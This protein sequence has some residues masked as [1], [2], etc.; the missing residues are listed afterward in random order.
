MGLYENYQQKQPLVQAL[1]TLEMAAGQKSLEFGVFES[2]AYGTGGAALSAVTAITNSFAALGTSIGVLDEGDFRVSTRDAME[3]LMGGRA[4]DFYGEYSQGIEITGLVAGS[5]VPGLAAVRALRAMQVSGKVP[6]VLRPITGQRNP[7]ML[8]GSNLVESAK[9]SVLRSDTK[10]WRSQETWRA[11]RG[12]FQQQVMENIAFEAGMLA[13]MNQHSILNPEGTGYFGAMAGQAWES[14]PFLGVSVALGTGI[15]ALRI[16]GAINKFV[17]SEAVRTGKYREYHIGA[18]MDNAAV[19]AGDKI[20]VVASEMTRLKSLAR[21]TVEGDF[22]ATRAHEQ[23]MAAL[24]SHLM[25]AITEVNFSGQVGREYA[26][27]IV[28][29]AETGRLDDLAFVMAGLARL[30]TPT[31]TDWREGLRFFEKGRAPKLF[32]RPTAQEAA[33]DF[34]TDG[35]GMASTRAADDMAAN[36]VD[37]FGPDMAKLAKSKNGIYAINNLTVDVPYNEAAMI[38]DIAAGGQMPVGAVASYGKNTVRNARVIIDDHTVTGI[39]TIFLAPNVLISDAKVIEHNWKI[40]VKMNKAAGMRQPSLDEYTEFLVMHELSHLKSNRLV[41]KKDAIAAIAELKGGNTSGR[42]ILDELIYGTYKARGSSFLVTA[43]NEASKAGVDPSIVSFLDEV[44]LGLEK[45]PSEAAKKQ[46]LG[47]LFA[48]WV[49]SGQ[50]DTIQI[51]GKKYPAITL[52]GKKIAIPDTS[53][54]LRLDELLAD[55]GAVLTHSST[56]EL[57]SKTMPNVARIMN[58]HGAIARAWNPERSFVD[59][60]TGQQETTVLFRIADLAGGA[61]GY[62]IQTAGLATHLIVPK[63]KTTFVSNPERFAGIS[64]LYAKAAAG[65]VPKESYLAYDAEWLIASKQDMQSLIRDDGTM[66][67]KYSHLPQLER[68][69]TQKSPALDTLFAK[70]NF[71]MLTE[72]GLQLG[73]TK[74]GLR[75]HLATE[76]Q[77]YRDALAATNVYSDAEIARILNISPKNALGDFSDDGWTM[78]DKWEHGEQRYLAAAYKPVTMADAEASAKSRVAV[79]VRRQQ[80]DHL[81]KLTS[82]YVIPDLVQFLPQI[83]VERIAIMSSAESRAGM[84][85]N[86]RPMF[87]SV[88]V[89]MQHVGRLVEKAAVQR[90]QEVNNRMVK[91]SNH[92]NKRE[93]GQDRFQLAQLE[94]VA[95]RAPYY[96]LPTKDGHAM[97]RKSAIEGFAVDNGISFAEAHVRLSNPQTNQLAIRGMIGQGDQLAPDAILPSRAIGDFFAEHIS[98]NRVFIEKDIALAGAKGRAI[99]RDPHAL[100]TPPRDLS[101]SRY[102]AFVVPK[103]FRADAD[104]RKFMVYADTLDEYQHK[105]AAIQSKYGDE[106]TV[107]TKDDV[108]EFKKYMGDYDQGLIFDEVYFDANMAR[109][110]NASELLPGVDLEVSGT[111]SR[112]HNWYINK[113]RAILRS[114]VETHYAETF[115]YLRSMDAATTAKKAAPFGVKFAD[116]T[117][118]FKDSEYLMLG[119]RASSGSIEDGWVRVNGFIGEKGSQL[120]DNALGIFRS[121]IGSGVTAK[122]LDEFNTA[123]ESAGYKAPF[124]GVMETVLISPDPQVSRALPSLVRTMNNL[125]GTLM[126]R[127]DAAHQIVTMISTPILALPVLMEA[128]A[129]MRGTPGGARLEAMTTVVNP[130]TGAKEPTAARLIYDGMRAFFSD[131]GK[132]FMAELRQQGVISDYLRQYQEVLDFSQINGRHQM[133]Q[134]NDKIDQLAA[135]GSR[136]S[137]FTQTEEFTRFYVAWAAKTIGEARGLK[138]PELM[139]VVASSVDKVHGIYIGHQRPQLFQGVVGQAIGLYQTYMFNF[140]QNLTKYVGDGDKAMAL[141]LAGMQSTVFG[142]QSWPGFTTFNQLIGETNRGN[143]DIYEAFDAN[144]PKATGAYFMYGLGSHVLGT[145]IDFYSRGDMAIRNALIVPN[146]LDPMQ[147]PAV[148]MFA[149][150][151]GNIYNVTKM[152]LGE[153]SVDAQEAILHG[154][155]HNGMNRPLQGLAK[156]MQGQI[157]SG[158]GQVLFENS[159]YV[160]YDMMQEYEWSSIFAR[161]I[162]TRPLNESIT[163]DA[164]YRKAAYQTTTRKQIEQLGTKVQLAMQGDNLDAETVTDFAQKYE[165]SGGD[166]QNFNAFIGRHLGDATRGSMQEFRNQLEADTELGRAYRRMESE[167]SATPPWQQ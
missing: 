68:L 83:D 118:I 27:R 97:V 152:A 124:A 28:K 85:G 79:D 138:G 31:L 72:G 82:N 62:T 154:L 73:L 26:E 133:K 6:T 94:Q 165:R 88:R 96:I 43:R 160:D 18:V 155:A 46:I 87:D 13:T 23:G 47:D 130:A 2:M 5:L 104:P 22:A 113:E 140:M 107:F 90:D 21:G 81:S 7:D 159:N 53:Y 117:S 64:G 119:K 41:H 50:G 74:D 135:F 3:G 164:Y 55:S 9:Q 33:A 71:F 10:P 150:A 44:R 58:E 1:D 129:A 158:S 19:P 15:D 77:K 136:V 137:L 141:T 59:L 147:I 101:K 49:R 156:I 60:L 134:I 4:G 98:E 143:I 36:I 146:P 111:L 42:A 65:K 34:L 80:L 127:L 100:Y 95:Q 139:S 112:W 149:R 132:K 25:T 148:G 86:L 144:D 39:P 14:L 99:V 12:G 63:L 61:A 108:G 8:L 116:E 84:F 120:I 122:Q 67:L 66:L 45:A 161:A 35:L 106:Y 17:A 57:A 76:K 115:S 75:K 151:A 153:E 48:S 54:Y 37:V 114:G 103:D 92:F 110:G 40:A 11:Y 20:A 102:F 24:R 93:N 163:T 157:T 125:A 51:A 91:W 52:G 126:L 123:L 162:G 78:F 131:D 105:V 70:G 16:N 38:A 32:I 121:D 128:K 30:D 29:E 89:Q 56:R 69:L 142:L 166:M 145:P 109:R 167:R